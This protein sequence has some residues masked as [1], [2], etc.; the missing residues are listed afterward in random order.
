M[1]G[2]WYCG[3]RSAYEEVKRMDISFGKRMLYGGLGGVLA[4][5]LLFITVTVQAQDLEVQ[6]DVD[7]N[8]CAS[9]H[10]NV[11]DQWAVS[12]HGTEALLFDSLNNGPIADRAAVAAEVNGATC[13]TC[14]WLGEFSPSHPEMVMHTD[15]SADLC[16]SCHRE[17]VAEWENSTHGDVDVACVRCHSPHSTSIKADSVQDLCHRCHTEEGHFYRNTPHAQEDLLCIDCHLGKVTA[18]EPYTAGDPVGS[19]MHH[20]FNVGLATCNQCHLDTMHRPALAATETITGTVAG[21]AAPPATNRIL[22][23]NLNL[24]PLT[25]N[26]ASV[27]MVLMAGIV[28]G[29]F[30]APQLERRLRDYGQQEEWMK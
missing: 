7:P 6:N 4:I 17:T 5:C 16:G 29:L 24:E 28:V 11:V 19:K 1:N 20:T 15:L 27:V 18:G 12:E 13:D 3:K 26:P 22:P 9:C 30:L 10:E 23:A 2:F 8:D 21:S 25:A 14:H